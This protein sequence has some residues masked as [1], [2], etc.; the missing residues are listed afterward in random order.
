MKHQ[1]TSMNLYHLTPKDYF[2]KSEKSARP[3]AIR[4]SLLIMALSELRLTMTL[5]GLNTKTGNYG[6]L[7]A[8]K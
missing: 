3:L 8:L 5:N 7:E 4:K 1:Y 2:T 6:D